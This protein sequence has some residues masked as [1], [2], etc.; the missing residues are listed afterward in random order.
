MVTPEFEVAL[1]DKKVVHEAIRSAL[2]QRKWAIL[3]NE[4]NAIEASYARGDSHSVRIRV[5]HTGNRVK[6]THVD[7]QDMLYGV[8]NSGPVI[9]RW[10]N[11]WVTNLERDIQVAVGSGM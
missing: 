3:K 4:P 10:Y 1:A 9:H 2:V 6:I 7:S 8:G 5:V 11:T